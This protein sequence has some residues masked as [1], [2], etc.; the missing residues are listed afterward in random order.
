MSGFG[1]NLAVSVN[2]VIGPVNGGFFFRLAQITNLSLRGFNAD[3]LVG[4]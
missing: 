2:Q 4:T 3:S 1:W